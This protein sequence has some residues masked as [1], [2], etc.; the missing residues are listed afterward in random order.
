[1]APNRYPSLE[2][3]GAFGAT[4]VISAICRSLSRVQPAPETLT[5][6]PSSLLNLLSLSLLTALKLS[7][8]QADCG[9]RS[10]RL[11]FIKA[12]LFISVYRLQGT[13]HMLPD[14]SM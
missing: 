5:H 12:A 2:L 1:M 6:L 9:S 8:K 11:P 7:V 10:R 13:K 14:S 3:A 4:P